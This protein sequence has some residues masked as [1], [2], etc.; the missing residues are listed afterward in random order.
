MR[1]ECAPCRWG[2]WEGE[3][4]ETVE[5]AQRKRIKLHNLLKYVQMTMGD[6]P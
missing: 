1:I 6:F 5:V 4:I 3:L 2:R